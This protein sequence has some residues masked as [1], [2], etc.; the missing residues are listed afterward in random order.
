ME[1]TWSGPACQPCERAVAGELYLL[2]IVKASPFAG[3]S[4]V[5]KQLD[6]F[7]TPAWLCSVLYITTLARSLC[8]HTCQDNVVA[9]SKAVAAAENEVNLVATT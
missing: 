9:L 7:V 1:T 5:I 2:K 4:V 8:T 6:C 3:R